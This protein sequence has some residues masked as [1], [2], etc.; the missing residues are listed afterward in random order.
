MYQC[1]RI[2]GWL[3]YLLLVLHPPVCQRGSPHPGEIGE[4]VRLVLCIGWRGGHL[5]VPPGAA[6]RWFDIFCW[7]TIRHRGSPH[8]GEIGEEV[9]LVLCIGWRGGHLLAPGASGCWF[10]IFCRLSIRH[11]GSPHPGE[12]R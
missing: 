11:R 7:L 6:C 12:I 1:C 5:V 10:D 9:R 4:E 2:F 3:R 8:P